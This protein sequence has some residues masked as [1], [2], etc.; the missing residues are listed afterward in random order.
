MATVKIKPQ[1]VS[2]VTADVPGHETTPSNP[3]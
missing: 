2:A 1:D 3:Q